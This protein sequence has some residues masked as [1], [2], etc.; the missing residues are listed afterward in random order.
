MK[1][2][3]YG[4]R[5]KAVNFMNKVL[6]WNKGHRSE[7]SG[8][9]TLSQSGS[10]GFG[11]VTDENSNRDLNEDY[12][13]TVTNK[14]VQKAVQGNSTQANSTNAQHGANIRIVNAKSNAN[15]NAESSSSK[16]NIIV[17][18]RCNGTTNGTASL[19]QNHQAQNG[20]RGSENLTENAGF[21][22]IGKEA[23]LV[24]ER[25]RKHAV[26]LAKAQKSVTNDRRFS[27][28]KHGD[29]K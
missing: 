21:T 3:D 10:G 12:A 27:C 22:D 2:S 5:Q 16:S 19:D 26:L 23:A 6:L 1:R 13:D 18:D 20:D 24:E 9:L 28:I 17:M 8:S 4:P 14:T 7:S 29:G 25:D 11:G 15:A